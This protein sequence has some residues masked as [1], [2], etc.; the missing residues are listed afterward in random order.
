[1]AKLKIM[2]Q[3]PYAKGWLN[4][5]PDI[6]VRSGHT[7]VEYDTEDAAA[8]QRARDIV[9]HLTTVYRFTALDT[10]SP[11]SPVRISAPLSFD[12]ETMTDVTLI[13]QIA[14]GA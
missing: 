6:K 2:G 3:A 9:G 5:W 1:M 14:G 10:T 13:P 8:R 4:S 12:P 11:L 7:V